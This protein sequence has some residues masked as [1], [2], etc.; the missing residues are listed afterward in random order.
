[1]TAAVFFREVDRCLIITIFIPSHQNGIFVEWKS[2]HRTSSIDLDG[3]FSLID[4]L[5][6]ICPLSVYGYGH[7]SES[8]EIFILITVEIFIFIYLEK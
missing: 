7:P 3:C 5:S 4:W 6:D 1:M 8:L 2:C